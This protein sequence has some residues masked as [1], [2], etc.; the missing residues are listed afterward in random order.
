VK[1]DVGRGRSDDPL[2]T[3]KGRRVR[4]GLRTYSGNTWTQMMTIDALPLDDLN[5]RSRREIDIFLDC[6]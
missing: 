4:R 2:R 5:A 6:M 1:K 3:V